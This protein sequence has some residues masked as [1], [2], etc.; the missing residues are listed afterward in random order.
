MGKFKKAIASL[1]VACMTMVTP[2]SA[3]MATVSAAETKTTDA[4]IST[5]MSVYSI[6]AGRKYFSVNQ[7]KEIIDSANQNGF[8]HV[9]LLFGN[10]G[11]RLV[12]DDMTITANG[13]TYASDDVKEAIKAG[14]KTYYD[15]PNGNVLNQKD[16]E[17]ILAYAKTKI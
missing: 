8:T 15:D 2:L 3:G 10:D 11:L 4:R 7:L 16:I 13:K 9:Q 14:T 12:L 6:D 1:L 17:T 5:K